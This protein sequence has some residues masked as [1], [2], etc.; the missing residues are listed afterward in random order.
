MTNRIV[1]LGGGVGTV[2]V[3]R[4]LRP[5]SSDITVVV[6]MADEGGSAGR[7]RR[8]YSVPPP[9]DLIN[10]IAALSDA[11]PILK[12]LLTYRFEGNRWGREDSIV[13]HK[14]GNL[15]L[16]ALTKILG[17]FN[18]ALLEMERI[19]SSHG[20]IIPST[21]ESVSIW[22][23]TTKGD[24][25]M[26]EETIDLGKY[27]DNLARVH[28]SPT[29]VS[30][31]KIALD[32]IDAADL[33]II[34]P[35]DLYTTIIPVLLVPEIIKAVYQSRAKK[36]YIFNIANKRETQNYTLDDHLNALIRHCPALKFDYLLVNTNQKPKLSSRLKY[37]YIQPRLKTQ[38][39]GTIIKSD[40]IDESFPVQHDPAKLAKKIL[41]VVK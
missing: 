25:V 27:K 32:S 4:G 29:N 15:I 40:V 16:V 20:K 2:Q 18:K 19:F 33:I 38:S 21:Y 41:Q 35:G 39:Y 24:K 9:G 5:Y 34:G 7:L 14:I 1:C 23:E 36:V 6:S 30:T 31:P 13:G 22:A 8:L 28:L 11:E 12:Q 17:D 26:G 10:C 37:Q 3:I